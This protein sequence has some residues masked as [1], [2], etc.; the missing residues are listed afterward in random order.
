MHVVARASVRASSTHARAA[1]DQSSL[2]HVARMVCIAAGKLG[3][4]PAREL[5][6]RRRRHLARAGLGLRRDQRDRLVGDLLAGD[7]V[8][9]RRRGGGRGRR[10][11]LV[12]SIGVSGGVGRGAF[13]HGSVVVVRGA[14]ATGIDG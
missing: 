10:P 5:G 12:R 1:S 3:L 4:E 13:A 7:R 14:S 6:D 9:R 2:T 11:E 8:G